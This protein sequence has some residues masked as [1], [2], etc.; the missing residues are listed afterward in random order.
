M[1]GLVQ[2]HKGEVIMKKTKMYGTGWRPILVALLVAVV[3]LTLSACEVGGQGLGGVAGGEETT[4]EEAPETPPPL[5]T[6]ETTETPP[7]PPPE[8][9][10][11]PDTG[12]ALTA[13]FS[14]AVG[15][16]GLSVQFTDTS[17]G[18]TIT[19]WQ[20]NFGDGSTSTA[21]NPSHTYA[22][23]GTYAVSLTVTDSEGR[24]A[25]ATVNVTVGEGQA[26]SMTC[27]FD[28]QPQGNQVPL[29][30]NFVN[31]STNATSYQWNF[32]DG[33]TS[34]EVSPSHVY[35]AVGDYPVTLTCTGPVGTLTASGMVSIGQTPPQPAGLTAQF[36]AQALGGLAVQFTD[37]SR[38]GTV[39][40]WQ[41]SFGDGT[42]SSEQNPRHTYSAAGTYT[43]TL[44]VT[45]STGRTSTATGTVEVTAQLEAPSPAFT[46]NPAEGIAPLT[47]TVTDATIGQVSNW[48]WDFGDG[49][50]ATGRGPHNHTYAQAGTY[51]ITLTVSGAGGGGT[52]TRQVVVIAE[53]TVVEAVFTYAL[54][55]EFTGSQQVCFTDASTG[56]IVSRQWSFGDGGS[57][58]EASPCHTYTAQ[59][60]YIV[61]LGVTGANGEIST[62]SQ[63]VPVIPGL[64]AP[65]AQ[66]TASKTNVFAGETVNFTDTST[67]VING[68]LW[69][70]GDGS[71][72]TEQN[73]SHTYQAAGSYV[74]TLTVRGPGGTSQAAQR[75]ITVSLKQISCSIGG[76]G[77][78]SVGDTYEYTSS[79]SGDNTAVVSTYAWTLNGQAVGNG[80]NLSQLF[81]QAGAQTL[82][83]TITFADGRTCS[84]T[85]TV[86]VQTL[87]CSISGSTTPNVGSAVTYT[88][89]V[90]SNG[91]VSTYS[92]TLNGQVRGSN[93]TQSLTFTEAGAQ[94]LGLTVTMSDG[95]SCSTTV[96]INVRQLVLTCS[97]SGSG[98]AAI[99]DT[100]SYS[101]NVSGAG[102]ATVSGYAW[103]FNGQSVGSGRT[104]SLSFSQSGPQTLSLAVTLS[105]GRTCN[106]NKT[107]N[108]QTLVC[109]ISGSSTVRIGDTISYSGSVNSNGTVSSYVW[110]LNGQTL[111]S[112]RN[113]S[114]IFS[115]LGPQTLGLSVTMADGRTCSASRT[116][117]VQQTTLACSIGGNAN[118]LLGDAT[119]YTSTVTGLGVATISSYAWTLNGQNVGNGQNQSLTFEQSG[120]QT[121]GLTV[122]LSDGRTCSA[123]ST[124]NVEAR[125]ALSATATPSS[126]IAP[127]LVDLTATGTNVTGN[128]VWTFPDGSIARGQSTQFLFTQPGTY[129]VLVT[130]GSVIGDLT[131]SVVVNVGSQTDIRA[132]FVPSRWGGIAPMQ[133][134]FTDRSQSANSQIV[135][136]QW[137]LGNGQTSTDQN[138]CTTYDT[139][140]TYN[141]SLTVQNAAGLTASATNSVRAFSVS[142]SSTSFGITPGPGLEVCFSAQL[143]PGSSVMWDFGDG[144]T[145]T[146]ANPCHTYPAPGDYTVTLIVNGSQAF[147]R[148]VTV[149]TQT[150]GTPPPTE[151]PT[152]TPS[153]TEAPTGTPSPTEVPTSTPPPTGTPLL[154]TSTPLPPVPDNVVITPAPAVNAETCPQFIVF[155]TFRDGN[156]EIY[157][158]DGVE[159]AGGVLY[160]LSNSPA[161][162]SRPSRSPD[163]EWVVFQSDRDGNIELYYTD[164]KGEQQIR[165]TRTN[166]NNINAMIGP[167]N[168]T[169][170]FQSDR[171]GN[172]DIFS[173]DLFTGEERQ[174]TTDPHNDINPFWSP[175]PNWIAFE[176]DRTGNSDILLLN[177]STGQE[178]QVTR[179][180]ANEIFPAWSP[181]GRQLA[182]LSDESGYWKLYVVDYTGEN[183][184]R[185]TSGPGNTGNATWSPDGNRIA[186]QDERNG[187]LNVYA[188]DLLTS[189]EYLLSEYAGVDSAPTWDCGGV[190][191]AFT[192]L[193]DGN[194]NLFQV[195]WQGGPQSNLTVDPATDKWSQW[196]PSKEPASRG[197]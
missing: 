97:I 18:G 74:V 169:V 75:T 179:G 26:Q 140:G 152:S 197:R 85:K 135:S 111:G 81:S 158:L 52:A 87:T 133:V 29:T 46:V 107:I 194:P 65:V 36:T 102:S 60:S 7:P 139:P 138:P 50:T 148:A 72:S 37:A 131:A 78:A 181:N 57:S 110:T 3:I 150:A 76:S 4:T 86:T 2:G 11:P 159:G 53:G 174:L 191:V 47:V 64:S 141:V 55:G 114:V 1:F 151:V 192:S 20:W 187:D 8:E 162:D 51:T 170:I 32:G 109:G 164:S 168:R 183:V 30:V 69:N 92:W 90:N 105:D 6:E 96:T 25:T 121:I 117:T 42:S 143:P 16:D 91:T 106:A 130:S 54:V 137:N 95:R 167:D 82:G 44:T 101:A 56:L 93:R 116:V 185:I 115:Q 24:S 66:F 99:G 79:F 178:F 112:S 80:Q 104:Q 33:G 39:V 186:Y 15:S 23:T 127:L 188:Y 163:D 173:I 41:W 124:V 145:D 45:D 157:R 59:G 147:S 40:S 177:L 172:W 67:G 146:S 5:P 62:A 153:P 155:H 126:G 103:T 58:T 195:F 122:T 27:L 125:P 175:D 71:T 19:G 196:S 184:I 134:C 120:R 118:P 49:S 128:Y 136:W 43:V 35:Q 70:F 132:A 129:E 180:A 98:S 123:S 189:R 9:T 119:N 14:A 38:G 149:T 108:V 31:T 89:N 190:N 113:Q 144:S 88:A 165:L 161:V 68:W 48:Q 12:G 160:N 84:T 193:R 63:V 171:N 17:S 83:L 154:P 13:S 28:I 94:T 34:T 100:R 10:P 182:Y 22:G 77:S 142:E 176:S 61:T 21:Q 166:A 73:P 156:L